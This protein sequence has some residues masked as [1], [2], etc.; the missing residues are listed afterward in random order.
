MEEDQHKW[1]S[2]K[3]AATEREKNNPALKNCTEYEQQKS[4][5]LNPLLLCFLFNEWEAVRSLKLPFSLPLNGL[6]P[7]PPDRNSRSLA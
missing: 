7:P 3:A 5:P 4:V 6:E 1:P 2:P